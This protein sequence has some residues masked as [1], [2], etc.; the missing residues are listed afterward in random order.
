MSFGTSSPLNPASQNTST[1]FA[2][3]VIPQSMRWPVAK[4]GMSLDRRLFKLDSQ[5]PSYSSDS[6]SIITFILPK[7]ELGDFRRS[8]L[9]LNVTLVPSGVGTYARLSQGAYSMFKRFR[10]KTGTEIED[11]REYNLLMSML[12]ETTLE[13]NIVDTIGYSMYGYGTQAERNAWGLTQKQYL[14]PI[15]SSFLA[16][17]L[18]PLGFIKETITIEFTL[19]IPNNFIEHDYTGGV[20][21]VINDAELHYD[22]VIPPLDYSNAVFSRLSTSGLR[23][24]AKVFEHYTNVLKAAKEMVNINHRTDSVESIVTI[25]RT[26]ADMANPA[27]NDK[28]INYQ[29]Y[30]LQQ[31]QS[32]INSVIYPQEPIIAGADPLETFIEYLKWIGRWKIRGDELN[33]TKMTMTSFESNKFLAI[34]NL[35]QHPEE[36]NA[37]INNLST[38]NSSSSVILELYFNAP[39]ASF[40][41]ADSFVE[42]NV[43]YEIDKMGRVTRHF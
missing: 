21:I 14:L 15:Y 36:E 39:P 38:K 32:K 18:I 23:M 19:D 27:I 13:D 8:C 6:G 41:R 12:I 28:F 40:V 31:Y 24:T 35:A 22:V 17:G 43:V 33:P 37:L 16:L 9:D 1:E 4:Q 20:K 26:D 11:L 29:R 34:I 25:F 42:Y 30:G 7:E 3:R 10:I 5:Q 2:S